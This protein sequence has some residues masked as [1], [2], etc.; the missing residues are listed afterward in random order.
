VWS[1]TK[2]RPT[3]AGS[4]GGDVPLDAVFD[5]WIARGVKLNPGASDSQLSAFASLVGRPLPGDIIAF[6]KRAN[7]MVDHEQDDHMVSFWSIERMIAERDEVAPPAIV[8]GDFLISSWY[9]VYRPSDAGVA[10]GVDSDPDQV[11]S[12]FTDFLRTYAFDP[13]SLCIL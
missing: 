4:A 10:I 13:G 3:T 8:F 12:S 6:Y 5:Q 11:F 2:H 1:F 7:G 9:F